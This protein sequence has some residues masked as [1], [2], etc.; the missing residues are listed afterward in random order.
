MA[1]LH[2]HVGLQLNSIE[3]TTGE[4]ISFN[5]YGEIL[6]DHIWVIM[7]ICLEFAFNSKSADHRAKLIEIWDSGVLVE[8]IWGTSYCSRSF[9]CHSL[10]ISKMAYNSETTEHRAKCI[11]LWDSH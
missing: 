11:A 3:H 1:I 5:I 9:R 10:H 6:T 4:L 2:V 8:D 7:C